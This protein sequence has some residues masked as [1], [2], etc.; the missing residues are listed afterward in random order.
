MDKCSVSALPRP[1]YRILRIWLSSPKTKDLTDVN[2]IACEN[3]HRWYLKERFKRIQLF[4]KD[5]SFSFVRILKR[6]VLARISSLLPSQEIPQFLLARVS[7]FIIL[8][9]YCW[10]R[11]RIRD[12]GSPGSLAIS[13]VTSWMLK[14]YCH[15]W[16]DLLLFE[17]SNMNKC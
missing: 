3:D 11:G 4:C 5:P 15:L 7:K 14:K 12:N 8:F 2:I 10:R 9:A 13:K 17:Y 16:N 1:K 6:P